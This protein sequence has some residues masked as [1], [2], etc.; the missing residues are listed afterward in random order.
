MSYPR[1]KV[2][3]A[4]RRLGFAVLR[5]GGAHTIVHRQSDGVRIAVP[6]HKELQRGTVRGMAE[7]AGADWEQFRKDVS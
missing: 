4:L 1:R 3:A 5:E 2:L 6:R 7:D